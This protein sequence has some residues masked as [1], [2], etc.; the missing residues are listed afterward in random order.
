M[1]TSTLE[2]TGSAFGC[3]GDMGSDI[4][5]VESLIEDVR[6]LLLRRGVN[7]EAFKLQV[8]SGVNN[9]SVSWKKPAFDPLEFDLK[10]ALKKKQSIKKK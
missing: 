5:F 9:Y 4:E 3:V 8:K 7:P 1:Y 10:K 6:L 2:I